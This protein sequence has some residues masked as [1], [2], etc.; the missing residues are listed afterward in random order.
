M[1]CLLTRL[2]Y[3]ALPCPDLTCPTL[4][5]C[6]PPAIAQSDLPLCLFAPHLSGRVLAFI[7]LSPLTTHCI[8]CN[9]MPALPMPGLRPRTDTSTR[10]LSIV[11]AIVALVII[12]LCFAFACYPKWLTKRPTPTKFNGLTQLRSLSRS[13][14]PQFPSHPVVM[15]NLHKKPSQNVR[16]YDPRTYSPFPNTPPKGDAVSLPSIKGAN[17]LAGLHKTSESDDPFSPVRARNC[18]TPIGHRYSIPTS[19]GTLTEMADYAPSLPQYGDAADYILALPEPLV[20]QARSAGRPPPLTRQIE[21]F[22]LPESIAIGSD[23][24]AHPKKLFE[25]LEQLGK[26][27]EHSGQDQNLATTYDVCEAG[28]S[29]PGPLQNRSGTDDSKIMGAHGRNAPN[30][31]IETRPAFQTNDAHRKKPPWN[32]FASKASDI[33]RSGTVTRPKTPVSEIRDYHNRGEKER[34]C[35]PWMTDSLSKTLTP[36]TEPLTASAFADSGHAT[37]STPP[38]SPLVH[39]SR[40][41]LLPTPLRS[42]KDLRAAAETPTPIPR[43]RGATPSSAALPE[44]PG[45]LAPLQRVL[46]RNCTRRNSKGFFHAHPPDKSGKVINPT[47]KP[48]P[49]KLTLA[50]SFRIQSPRVPIRRHSIDSACSMLS[51]LVGYQGARQSILASSI[52]SRDTKGLSFARSPISPN[53]AKEPTIEEETEQHT[54]QAKHATSLDLLRKIDNWDLTT[55]DVHLSSS[56]TYV[57]KRAI[58]DSG[59]YSPAFPNPHPSMILVNSAQASTHRASYS[60]K[61]SIPRISIGRPSDDIFQDGRDEKDLDHDLWARDT[62]RVLKRVLDMEIARSRRSRMSGMLGKRGAPGG[63]DWI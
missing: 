2:P 31:S 21:K 28:T 58:S 4:A 13:P 17:S 54:P 56:P 3:P 25:K 62:T 1:F 16:R 34:K 55:H 14:P 46:K 49:V 43:E 7:L 11:F 9:I 57:L 51:P 40:L 47:S 39:F 33:A 61:T 22:P 29:R 52:Y 44:S 30:P 5:G 15:R 26:E 23:K 48:R 18:T 63:A 8:L 35:K 41:P 45:K 27:Q 6:H 19:R 42:R 12:C 32:P 53:F 10:N 60:L 50:S 20:L 24:L 36:S 59:A 37:V 38:S